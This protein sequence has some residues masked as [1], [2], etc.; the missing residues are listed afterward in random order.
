MTATEV[1]PVE[2][3]REDQPTVTVHDFRRPEGLTRPQRELVD[4][5]LVRFGALAGE[6]LA[7]LLRC[8]V[9]LD[10][11]SVD[12]RSWGDLV[13]SRDDH[14]YPVPFS[15][16]PL[17]GT[18]VLVLPA[19][20]ARIIADL[21][22]AGAGADDSADPLDLIEREL[23][24]QVAQSVLDRLPEA[25]EHFLTA[26][27]LLDPPGNADDP[28]AVLGTDDACLVARYGLTLGERPSCA[29]DLC[30]GPQILRDLVE[31]VRSHVARQDAGRARPPTRQAA[32]QL[33]SVPLEVTVQFPAIVATAESVLQLA[34]GDELALGIPTSEPLEVRAERA[35][36]GPGHHRAGRRPQGVFHRR[37]GT[38]MTLS[39]AA[40]PP[41]SAA[42]AAE[43]PVTGV[44]P[45]ESPVDPTEQLAVRQEQFRSVAVEVTV[46]IGKTRR[47]LGELARLRP[48]DVLELDT[49]LGAPVDVLVNREVVIA[50][51]EVVDVGD[52][53]G[54]RI[55][56]IVSDGER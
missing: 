10:L 42:P 40:P 9:T 8:P 3:H 16:Q 56:E 6:E 29:V 12:D 18:A 39:D 50:R 47:T 21:R 15:L 11:D 22:L 20:T 51:G 43:A 24:G 14:P 41:G 23:A 48:G 32:E 7:T 38:P 54:V 13:A 45:P 2:V 35:A 33:A 17:A 49:A 55:T 31:A 37:G 26:T 52:Q 5:A 1:Q 53:Y 25:F 4:A 30:L 28:L 34:V 36:R 44:V 27:A 46:W 19:S